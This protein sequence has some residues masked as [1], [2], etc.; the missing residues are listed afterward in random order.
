[1]K[2]E[3][4]NPQ[5]INSSK[6]ILLY[7]KCDNFGLIEIQPIIIYKQVYIILAKIS[8]ISFS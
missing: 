8:L 1:M 4:Y 5:I 2:T 7:T 6:V 3:F